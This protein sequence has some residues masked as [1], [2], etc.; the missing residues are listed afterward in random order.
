MRKPKS[1][2]PLS[3]RY[4]ELVSARTAL[5]GGIVAGLA[6]LVAACG[7]STPRQAS[8]A[9]PAVVA[10][11][12]TPTPVAAASAATPRPAESRR[13][14]RRD[15]RRAE[16]SPPVDPAAVALEPIP[17]SAQQSYGRAVAAL[18]AQDW[19]QAELD[20]EQVT[21]A[22]PAYPG[23]QVNLAIVYLHG[24]RRDDARAALDRALSIAP[25]NA[26]ANNQLGI[27]L[28]TEGKFD[29]AERAYRRA[30]QTDANY[31]LAHYN[32]GVL[33]DVYLRRGAEAIEHYE[34]YQGSLSEPDKTVAGWLIDLRRRVGN[35]AR[36]SQVAKED[37]A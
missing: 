36:A 31:A 2:K 14:S 8:T 17:E 28:R 6:A 30:L 4:V 35:A 7:A 1:E 25:G 23:P 20:L 5:R 27:L 22:F 33:L 29:E 19:L 11:A 21:H 12:A 34:A 15:E 9:A 18:H 24:G 37:G 3:M 16:A 26:A 32:L 13:G 10:P